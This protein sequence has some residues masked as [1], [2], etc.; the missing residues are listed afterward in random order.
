MLTP[1]MMLTIIM[2]PGKLAKFAAT[3]R[4]RPLGA[5]IIALLF[6]T[7]CGPPG[8]RSLHR[9]DRLVQQGQYEDAIDP[10]KEAVAELSHSQPLA[11]SRA[12]NLLGV[13]EQG[14]GHPNP[15][16]NAY[17]QALKLDR[18]LAVVDY[19]LG[20]L[21]LQQSDFPAAIASLTTF[22]T[23]RPREA[24]GYS[25]LG[26]AY[27][28]LSLSAAPRDRA[29]QFD[30]AIAAYKTAESLSPSAE[31]VNALGLAELLRR[32]GQPS[33]DALKYAV[34]AFQVALERSTN[35]PPALLNLAIVDQQYLN[36]SKAALDRYHQYLALDPAPANTNEV[37]RLAK[38]LEIDSRIQIVQRPVPKPAT[39]TPPLPAPPTNTLAVNNV[40]RPPP[41][42]ETQ[43]RPVATAPD[44]S[45]PAPPTRS[46]N[47]PPTEIASVNRTTPPPAS[48]PIQRPVEQA[49]PPPDPITA[50]TTSS[51]TPT[52]TTAPVEE[53][54]APTRPVVADQTAT[55]DAGNAQTGV[56]RPKKSFFD[57]LNPRNWVGGHK[58]K[59]TNEMADANDGARYSYPLPVTPIPGNRADAQRY[60]QE[61][62]KAQRD[63]RLDD[64]QGY[65]SKALD[66]DSTYFQ[67]ALSLGLVS[68]DAKDYATALTA[69]DKA[70]KL[71]SDSADARYAF[72]WVLQKKKYYDDSADELEKLLAVHPDSARAHLLLG[73]LYAQKLDKPHQAREHYLRVL[74]LDPQ[75]SQAPTIT[76][77][78]KQNP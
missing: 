77:W 49:Q 67:A 3:C 33:A 75:N 11:A 36:D 46:S 40:K 18:N 53:A 39:P 32:P 37:A 30:A 60:F 65:Y 64:A 38:Q 76:S 5:A 13:A 62:V 52:P 72:A 4:S 63:L 16:W 78:L 17:Q 19:N 50:P 43:P 6:L 34:K 25:R 66:I 9:G 44:R 71:Q 23:L 73:N 61:G 31:T 14:A 41:P 48:Q 1:T 59:S 26:D 74:T 7:G 68:I 57:R 42:T 27:L 56:T 51:P 28:R 69:L 55:L 10:L 54:P 8:V 47:P 35:Y 70:L 15:A 20:C 29:R 24:S 45:N 12:W 58:S 21:A 22:T 2:R